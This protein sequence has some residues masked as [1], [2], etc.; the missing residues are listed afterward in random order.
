MCSRIFSKGENNLCESSRL[1]KQ[2]LEAV[3]PEI[4]Y[5]STIEEKNKLAWRLRTSRTLR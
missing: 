1:Y 4:T 2:P 3:I 5:K